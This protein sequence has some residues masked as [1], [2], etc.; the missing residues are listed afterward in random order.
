MYQALFKLAKH[1]STLRLF[2]MITELLLR[3][4]K[5]T[6]Y[7]SGLLH[8]LLFTYLHL[9]DIK[10]AERIENIIKFDEKLAPRW[11][12]ILSDFKLDS[13]EST[14]KHIKIRWDS[15]VKELASYFIDEI[16]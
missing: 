3:R 6:K 14:G 4:G 2:C 7:R 16:E 9:N 12:F 10:N 15:R 11:P 13:Q 8:K 1:E 5:V